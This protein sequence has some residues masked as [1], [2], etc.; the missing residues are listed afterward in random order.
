[1]QIDLS[2]RVALVTGSTRG[3]GRAIAERLAGAGATVAVVGRDQGRAEEAAA[4]IGGSARGFA[5]DVSDVAQAAALVSSVE[6]TLGSCDILVNNAGLTRDNLLLRLKDDDWNAVIDANLRGAFAT[7]RAASRGMMKRRWG[8]M[9]NIAS[10]V[11]I[12]GNKGQAN[13]AASKAG[14]IG[15]TKS[16]AKELASRNILANVVA[17]GLIETDMT[18][19]MPDE[20]RAQMASAIPLERVGKPEDIANAVLFLASDLAAY[21]T[22]QVLVV[23]GGM[24]M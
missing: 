8:R 9:I 15:L 13:Y 22:G 16:V 1:M 2:G 6:Q 4:Q 17:P 5:C 10:V 23:D 12:T 7:M 19:A 14:L 20:A 18:A 11:G 24:V 21:V 3:I